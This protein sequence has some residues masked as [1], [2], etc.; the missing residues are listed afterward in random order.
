MRRYVPIGDSCAAA[1]RKPKVEASY[2]Q[3]VLALFVDQPAERPPFLLG[4][5]TIRCSRIVKVEPRPG[6]LSTV[7]SPPINRYCVCRSW[8]PEEPY[9]PGTRQHDLRRRQSFVFGGRI[10]TA[11]AGTNACHGR[12]WPVVSVEIKDEGHGRRGRRFRDLAQA[13][14]HFHHPTRT[15]H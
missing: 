6:S 5:S 8:H 4:A 3:T 11:S 13:G 15:E 7:M 10:L 14:D 1:K 12:G 2:C 9:R